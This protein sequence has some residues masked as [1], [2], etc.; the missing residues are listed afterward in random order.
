LVPVL[1]PACEPKREVTTA[2]AKEVTE[3]LRPVLDVPSGTIQI[4]VGDSWLS[5][6]RAHHASTSSP[7]KETAGNVSCRPKDV[8]P[9]GGGASSTGDRNGHAL[10]AR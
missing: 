6:L 4:D 3:L 2:G 8:L 5:D 10:W 9:I 1:Q 7:K